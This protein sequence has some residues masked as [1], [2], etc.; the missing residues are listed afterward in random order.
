MVERSKTLYKTLCDK[1]CVVVI[2]QLNGN[3]YDN[4]VYNS[5]EY[6]ALKIYTCAVERLCL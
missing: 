5:Y 3:L 1:I 2:F 6:T 4:K